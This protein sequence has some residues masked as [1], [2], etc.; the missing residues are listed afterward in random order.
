V[1]IEDEEGCN[2]DGPQFQEA[3]TTCGVEATFK[4]NPKL[5][6]IQKGKVL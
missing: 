4:I 3:N 2:G 6:Q 5:N 1:I